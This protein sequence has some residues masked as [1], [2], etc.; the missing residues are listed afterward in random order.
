MTR[1]V[2]IKDVAREAGVS[3]K[4]VSNVVNHTG[5]MRQQTRER[6]E[7][8]MRELG[9]KVNV[10]ARSLKTGVSNLIGLGIF[11]FSQ[12]FARISRIRLSRSPGVTATA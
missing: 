2:T 4:T 1:R 7:K 8:S 5:S 10:S 3:I 11:D 9:Y 12:P 6:V